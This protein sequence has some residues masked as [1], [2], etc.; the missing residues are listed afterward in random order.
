VPGPAP[1]PAPAL[2]L[3]ALA[4]TGLAQ[5]DGVYQ[6]PDLSIFGRDAAA[7]NPASPPSFDTLFGTPAADVVCDGTHQLGPLDSPF[8][9]QGDFVVA[10]VCQC[11]FGT[12]AVAAISLCGSGGTAG[13]PLALNTTG[14]SVLFPHATVTRHF[15][16]GGAFHVYINRRVSGVCH[17]RV[18]GS[19]IGTASVPGQQTFAC[20]FPVLCDPLPP[21][22]DAVALAE[23]RVYDQPMSD[24]DF[25]LV[26][27]ELLDVLGIPH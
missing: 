9:L 6:W 2:W 13:I 14:L 7:Q 15:T 12:N 3:K 10:A 24:A 16:H 25:A 26:E 5:G 4:L 21:L 8:Q 19:E 1:A 23:L 11:G 18:D 17:L 22:S 27:G 20:T